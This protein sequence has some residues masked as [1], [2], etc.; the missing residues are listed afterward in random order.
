MTLSNPLNAFAPSRNFLLALE[1]QE[2]FTDAGCHN[3]KDYLPMIDESTN[4]LL[5]MLNV[6]FEAL[7]TSYDDNKPEMHV[8]VFSSPIQQKQ[9]AA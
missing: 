8:C 5:E 7:H 2:K 9:H 6:E 3:G 4:I 1:F